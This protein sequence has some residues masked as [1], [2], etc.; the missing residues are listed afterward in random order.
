MRR[1]SDLEDPSDRLNLAGVCARAAIDTE[2]R[3]EHPRL[4]ARR[5]DDRVLVALTPCDDPAAPAADDLIGYA[6]R[7]GERADELASRDPLP[8]VTVTLG[9][10]RAVRHPGGS[11][12]P[13]PTWS[14]WPPRRRRTPR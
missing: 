8:S 10:L 13:T 5:L 6:L 9:E 12:C 3:L 7:L 4:A 11:L 1:G 14:P 2:T